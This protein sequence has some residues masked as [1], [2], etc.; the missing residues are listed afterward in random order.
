ML[1]LKK[2]IYGYNAIKVSHYKLWLLYHYRSHYC[3]SYHDKFIEKHIL[4]SRFTFYLLYRRY[5]VKLLLFP[6][7]YEH[8][9]DN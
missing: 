3:V 1:V 9:R 5:A 6:I 4:Q 2:G 8:T 7:L